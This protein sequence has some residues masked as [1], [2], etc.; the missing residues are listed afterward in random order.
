VFRSAAGRQAEAK[1]D[2]IIWST[3]GDIDAG[4]GAKT[5]RVPSAPEVVTDT[6]GVTKVL[7]RADITGSGIGTIIGLPLDIADT[8]SRKDRNDGV[9]ELLELVGLPKNS[10]ERYPHQRQRIVIAR[11]L[12]QSGFCR[13]RRAGVGA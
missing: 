2:E 11:A 5:A 13:L 8:H 6:D 3:R 4:R 9:A 7:E 10:V 1:G 12:A